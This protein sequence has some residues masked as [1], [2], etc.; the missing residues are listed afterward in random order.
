MTPDFLDTLNL[1]GSEHTSLLGT[2]NVS[3][4]DFGLANAV[5]VT[6]LYDV[7]CFFGAMYVT[8]YGDLGRFDSRARDSS[9][10][11]TAYIG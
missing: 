2:G 7:G 11:I 10:S 5:E 1:G 6:A 3:E 8:S 4:A 9:R